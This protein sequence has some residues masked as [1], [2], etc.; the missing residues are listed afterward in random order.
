VSR[1]SNAAIL[2]L[3]LLAAA[4]SYAQVCKCIDIG[5]IKARMKEAE[6]AINAYSNESRKMMEQMVRTQEPILYT[7]AR[8]EKL[9]GH[10]QAALNQASGG[11]ISPTPHMG[12]GPGHTSNVCQIVIDLHPSATACM[13]ESIKRHEEHHSKECRKTLT[14]G[15]VL[16]SVATGKDRFERN[17]VQLMQYANEEIAGYMTELTFLQGELM[18]L[19]QA[20][21]CNPKPK[22][23]VRDYTAQPRDRRAR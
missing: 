20:E 4:P 2:S 10:V 15:K 12:H 13:R 17:N 14:A 9:Q 18:R 1:F 16:D 11:R 8:R 23:E 7:P 3:F 5:D 21:E 22:P 6:T 19:S